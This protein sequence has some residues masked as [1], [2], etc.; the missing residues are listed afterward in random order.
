M[1]VFFSPGPMRLTSVA[2][3]HLGFFLKNKM[4]MHCL[5]AR[6][7]LNEILLLLDICLL[8]YAL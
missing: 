3:I 7:Y 4:G 6:A 8:L 2:T 1:E 5:V